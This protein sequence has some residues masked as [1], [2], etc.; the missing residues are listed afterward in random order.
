L[1]FQ[2]G[3]LTI[4]GYSAVSQHY[5]LGFP[6][7][8]VREAFLDSLVKQFAQLDIDM[9]VQS[10]GALQAQ[11]LSSFFA[12]IEVTLAGFPYHLFTEAQERTYHGMILSLMR[13]MGLEVSAER[14]SHLGRVDLL[15]ELPATTY[16]LEL[17]LDGSAEAALAQIQE[18]EYHVPYLHKG[19]EVAIVGL[20]FSS[21]TRNLDDWHG[22]LLDAQ[23]KFLR[24]L[25]PEEPLIEDDL[26][27]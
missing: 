5:Q 22:K 10:K 15:I 25:C 14:P 8:E 16:V 24:T 18:K 1:M 7:Q 20:N 12:K 17:K 9:A 6:N 4:T 21:K 2:T 13:G 11:D 19:K 26:P 27:V 23:G 3:Y